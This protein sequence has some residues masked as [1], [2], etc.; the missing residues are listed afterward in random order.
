MLS[1]DVLCTSEFVFL[2]GGIIRSFSSV[3]LNVDCPSPARE[4][5]GFSWPGGVWRG[6]CMGWMV[7]AS[8]WYA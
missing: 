1:M 3:A 7:V 5:G 2:S 4:M 6:A 8:S